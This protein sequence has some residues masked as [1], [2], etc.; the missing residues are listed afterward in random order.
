[1]KLNGFDSLKGKIIDGN[2]SV[3]LVTTKGVVAASWSFSHVLE[4]WNRKHRLAAYVP[5][6][7]ANLL[8]PRLKL[9]F[10]IDHT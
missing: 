1:M 2:G 3:D 4:H 10:G 6:T 8:D 5:K 7:L 9:A